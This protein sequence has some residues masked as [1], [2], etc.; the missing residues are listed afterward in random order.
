MKQG[1]ISIDKK[2][3]NNVFWCA[4]TIFVFKN[5]QIKF[6]WFS[7]SYTDPVFETMYWSSTRNIK[8]AQKVKLNTIYTNNDKV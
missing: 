5:S 1:N 8:L 6:N 2:C 3:K 4:K 7:F